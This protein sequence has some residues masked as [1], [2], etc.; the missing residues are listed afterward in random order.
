M[1]KGSCNCGAVSFEISADLK[2]VYVCHCSICRRASGGEA[3]AVLLVEKDAFH[4]LS[5]EAFIA[6]W[7][8]PQ[9]RYESYFCQ[10]C[11]SLVPGT[12][13]DT[14]MFVPAG[15]I[16]EGGENLAV[17]DHLYVDS[18]APWTCIGD[19]GRQHPGAYVPPGA[20]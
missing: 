4:W 9:S 11:G 15:L 13:S 19:N 5:G 12:N 1:A 8:K 2:D 10:T 7:R 6:T 20:E 14:H 17:S 3:V 18:A 16:A